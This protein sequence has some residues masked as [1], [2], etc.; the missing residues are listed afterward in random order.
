M[1]RNIN[2]CS[3]SGQNNR[4]YRLPWGTVRRVIIST[5]HQNININIRYSDITSDDSLLV[6]EHLFL[7]LVYRLDELSLFPLLLARFG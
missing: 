2:Y 1:N 5:K 6:H 7:A 4:Y 3:D